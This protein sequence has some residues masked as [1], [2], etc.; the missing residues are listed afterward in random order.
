MYICFMYLECLSAYLTLQYLTAACRSA[1]LHTGEVL[2]GMGC[3]GV[4]I[5]AIG[6][7]FPVIES[8]TSW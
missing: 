6:W 3:F 5:V 4:R 1:G 2:G 8:E 7:S